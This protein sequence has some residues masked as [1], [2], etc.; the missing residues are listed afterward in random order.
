MQNF[1]VVIVG[2]GMVGAAMALSLSETSLRVAVIDQHSLKPELVSA[3]E[4]YSPRVSALTDASVKLLKNLG[5]WDIMVSQRVC[6]YRHMTVWDGEGTGEIS[7]DADSVGY[8]QLGYIVENPV[9]RQSLLQGLESTAVERIE[10]TGRLA[11]RQLEHGYEVLPEDGEPLQCQLLV[12]ADG[13]ESAVRQWA[14]IPQSQKDCLHHAIVTTVET[15]KKH[16]DTAWQVFLDSGPLAFLPLPDQG[17]KHYCSIVW[18]LLPER[19]DEVML[20]D[21]AAFCQTLGEVFENRLGH[22]V[23]AGQ[24][25]RFPLKHRHAKHYFRDGVVLVGD[26]CHTIHPLAGQGVNL[27]FQD[28]EAL[29][30]ELIRAHRRGDDFSGAHIL[31]RYQR[32]RIADNMAML[33]AMD[34]FQ[35]L[36]HA[37]DIGVRWLR[38]TGLNLVN[39]S[40]FIKELI[41]KQAMG[42]N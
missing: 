7:F 34:G 11:F 2:G 24:K 19:A 28:V 18:S 22:V 16:Q 21:D 10:A 39:D 8:P 20:L 4:S 14:G 5:V 25:H 32:Q 6:P 17:G 27:G 3:D 1:D 37:D 31:G 41:I 35:H 13:A 40:H 30:K 33:A 23:S 12:G 38:N 36:F 9:I 29:A 15:E 26:A 42:I